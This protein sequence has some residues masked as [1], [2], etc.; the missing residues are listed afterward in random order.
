MFEQLSHLEKR[1]KVLLPTCLVSVRWF[2]PNG[3]SLSTCGMGSLV[4]IIASPLRPVS[5][6]HKYLLT[7]CALR[8]SSWNCLL[9]KKNMTRFWNDVGLFMIIY[10]YLWLFMIVIDY[11]WLFTKT[12]IVKLA[13]ANPSLAKAHPKKAKPCQ[14]LKMRRIHWM[15]VPSQANP[16]LLRDG[17]PTTSMEI[18]LTLGVTNPGG[19][20]IKSIKDSLWWFF[21]EMLK[22]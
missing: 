15:L 9:K 13:N 8:L 5:S 3:A 4:S 7:N 10:D 22:C 18:C 14:S 12:V 17:F 19:T 20:I 11:L 1:A 21:M 2:Q 6:T 16:V